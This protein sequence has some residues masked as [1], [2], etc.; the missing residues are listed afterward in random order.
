MGADVADEVGH[1][2]RRC[3]VDADGRDLALLVEQARAVGDGIA[4]TGVLGIFA[5]ER[6]PGTRVG[7]AAQVIED[8]PRFIEQRQRLAG[9]NV[10][11]C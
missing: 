10:R 6:D 7:I 4:A 8:G 3:A 2:L 5:R 9:Q 1:V 11:P